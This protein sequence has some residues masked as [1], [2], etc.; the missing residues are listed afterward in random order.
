LGRQGSQVIEHGRAWKQSSGQGIFGVSSPYSRVIAMASPRVG[1][2]EGRAIVLVNVTHPC[3][4]SRFPGCGR[5]P[6]GP[7]AA[8]EVSSRSLPKFRERFAFWI[9]RH[10]G[11]ATLKSLSSGRVLS[12]TIGPRIERVWC[13]RISAL[14]WEFTIK[15]GEHAA[16][17]RRIVRRPRA[18]SEW[19]RPPGP[20]GPWSI[21]ERRS[22]GRAHPPA[23]RHLPFLG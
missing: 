3:Q 18:C 4:V 11:V 20:P 6:P 16:A 21:R 23:R 12:I 22:G 19:H 9:G 7:F 1:G 14:P 8:L 2:S 17:S 13:S 10:P 5:S 15:R